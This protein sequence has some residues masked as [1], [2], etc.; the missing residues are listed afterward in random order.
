MYPS[1]F[2]GILLIKKHLFAIKLDSRPMNNKKT[3]FVYRVL[4][5]KVSNISDIY[6]S[7][8]FTS[9]KIVKLYLYQD[10]FTPLTSFLFLTRLK[11]SIRF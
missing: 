8:H 2:L 7:S 1:I 5:F 4:D 3:D 10:T 6:A 9:I 11:R